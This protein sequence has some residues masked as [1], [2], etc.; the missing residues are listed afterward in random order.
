MLTVHLFGK[1]Q[2]RYGDQAVL[3]FP[4]QQCHL[5]LI[6]LLL[7]RP[8]PQS[9]EQMAAIFWGEASEAVSRKNLRCA[10]WRLRQGL[11]MAGA[12]VDDYLLAD[13]T[14]VSFLPDSA[15]WFDVEV[16]ERAT[17]ACRDVPGEFLTP[18][19]AS[20]LTSASELYRGDLLEG[21]YE[22]W[23]LSARE[24][25]GLIYQQALQKLMLYHTAR[26]AFECAL[27]YGERLLARDN[28]HE[29]VHRHLMTL[30]WLMGDRTAALGQ[31]KRCAQILRDE[32]GVAPIP[33]TVKIYEA[34]V[35]NSYCAAEISQPNNG[36]LHWPQRPQESQILMA[37]ITARMRE[38]Q[39]A[40]ASTQTE[41][42]HLE[43]LLVPLGQNSSARAD[44]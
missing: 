22:D 23:C 4:N 13:D 1:G 41:L 14:T 39:K 29:A 21:I 36:P 31:Y 12:P 28:T 2:V 38:L 33:E 8:Y 16:F 5:L 9:R 10:L 30:Y 37:Q 32:L 15:H 34:M 40:L 3:G 35:K 18:E 27:A 7:N 11:Q 17:R 42:K 25:L 20:E 19:Q 43:R 26:C 44:S 6:Y 24:H